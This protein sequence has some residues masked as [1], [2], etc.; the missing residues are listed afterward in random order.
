MT[1]RGENPNTF[2]MRVKSQ[3][4]GATVEKVRKL[5]PGQLTKT[6]SVPMDMKMEEFKKGNRSHAG[7]C[8][9]AS[10]LKCFTNSYIL[11]LNL[12]QVAS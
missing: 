11:F 4:G 2:P 9:I 10:T 7:Y 5:K 1:Q 12:L 3:S 8:F 6:V